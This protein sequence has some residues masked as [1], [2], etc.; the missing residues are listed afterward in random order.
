MVDKCLGCHEYRFNE[1]DQELKLMFCS[2]T[3]AC[4]AGY[5]G[6]RTDFVPK[7]TMEELANNKVLQDELLN[8][9]PRRVR[10]KGRHL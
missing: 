6:V 8:N 7:H 9:S 3:C 1:E 5:M 4:L 2:I 10:D